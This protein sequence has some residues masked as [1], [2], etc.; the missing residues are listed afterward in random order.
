MLCV[1]GSRLSR[2]AWI[3]MVISDH[4]AIGLCRRVSHEAR[5]LKWRQIK[6]APTAHQSRLSR[7]AWIKMEQFKA[8]GGSIESRLSRGAW[9]K[10]SSVN[11]TTSI[12]ICRVSH[13][14]RGLKWSRKLP[15][16]LSPLSR[17]SRG[18]WIKIPPDQLPPMRRFCR[19]S[20]EARGLKCE[21][22]S[23]PPKAALVA[24]LTR[25]V[26]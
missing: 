12:A 17:L 21:S 26:D 4:G 10:I 16:A 6:A 8:T 22:S 13:E 19:V 23:N 7:G 25:R 11:A 2:G 15:Q 14:A 1:A 9:I 24:S 3:K 18:A 20:H 5:G